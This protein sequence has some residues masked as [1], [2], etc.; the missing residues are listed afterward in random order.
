MEIEKVING[1]KRTIPYKQGWI[2][3]SVIPEIEDM[4]MIETPSQ[5]TGVVASSVKRVMKFVSPALAIKMEDNTIILIGKDN[6]DITSE[7]KDIKVCYKN[8]K[9]NKEDGK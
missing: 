6:I 3:V 7:S 1:I 4:V 9:K 5:K 8:K 2:K